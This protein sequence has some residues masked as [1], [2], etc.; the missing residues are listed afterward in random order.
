VSPIDSISPTMIMKI[1]IQLSMPWMRLLK[2]IDAL[3]G[4]VM[5]HDKA[6]VV[7]SNETGSTSILEKGMKTYSKYKIVSIG[8]EPHSQE[9]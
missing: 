5:S 8:S 4:K 9:N 1:Y 6:V 7:E 3:E 2:C